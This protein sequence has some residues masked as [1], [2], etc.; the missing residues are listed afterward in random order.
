MY[1]FDSVLS[2]VGTGSNNYYYISQIRSTYSQIVM[3][4]FLFT[5][6]GTYFTKVKRINI[7][8]ILFLYSFFG[9]IFNLKFDM[10]TSIV[11]ILYIV[12]K[13]YF[14]SVDG[15]KIVKEYD[16]GINKKFDFIDLDYIL[17]VLFISKLIN[18][19]F[20]VSDKITPHS[21]VPNSDS[22]AIIDSISIFFWNGA[23]IIL[24]F[25]ILTEIIASTKLTIIIN[26]FI[27]KFVD[28]LLDDITNL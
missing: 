8:I 12:F 24:I 1:I 23:C 20:N 28:L 5:S 14:K 18:D 26:K 21:L 22:F 11:V 4:I 17:A 6:V 27:N 10:L 16:L 13:K 9:F 2:M 3:L 25:L 15:K 19:Y 7:L